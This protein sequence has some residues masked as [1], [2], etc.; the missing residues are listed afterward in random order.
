MALGSKKMTSI[1]WGPECFAGETANSFRFGI[2]ALALFG[3]VM[4]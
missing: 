1:S 4:A 3:F 2:Q